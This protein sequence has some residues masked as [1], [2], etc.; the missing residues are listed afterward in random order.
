L[1][2][3][4]RPVIAV[5]LIGP[6]AVSPILGGLHQ[7]DYVIASERGGRMNPLSRPAPRRLH[8]RRMP[9]NADW[10][11]YF[12]RHARRHQRITVQ[13]VSDTKLNVPMDHSEAIQDK[14]K[15]F[16]E[17]I[18]KWWKHVLKKSG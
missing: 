15:S 17:R 13:N 9:A 16:F 14:P 8:R 3:I 1:A 5:T 4:C 2:D 12:L 6:S 10:S 18:S 7:S 11:L